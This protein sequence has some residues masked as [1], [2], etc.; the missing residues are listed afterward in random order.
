MLAGID[1]ECV[2]AVGSDD[3]NRDEEEDDEPRQG[4]AEQGRRG[5][6]DARPPA[7]ASPSR[8]EAGFGLDG[9]FLA[10]FR[11]AAFTSCHAFA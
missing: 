1:R 8:L 4:Q 3:S 6:V 7:A 10:A 9:Q 5:Q 2:E 11:Q